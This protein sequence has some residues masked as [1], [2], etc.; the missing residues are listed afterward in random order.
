MSIFD[1]LAAEF[2]REA[3]SW[4]AQTVSKTTSKGLALAYIDARDVMRRLDEAVG[5]ENWTDRY[6]V[7]GS[8]T[9]CY[10]SIRLNGEWIVKADGA[11][12]T[13]VEA[14]KGSIS[15]AFKRAAVK[16]GIGRYL[17]DLKTPW[18]PC[19]FEERNGK[20]VWKKW[21]ADPWEY[22]GKP[23]LAQA[24]RVNPKK[25]EAQKV[26][27]VEQDESKARYIES[28]KDKIAQRA[29]TEAE[30]R[31]WW[32]NEGSRRRAF[33]LSQDEVDQLKK[34]LMVRLDEFKR[35]A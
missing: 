23:P 29:I 13:D 34:L 3:V 7:H 25:A 9:I 17:Y 14:E 19:E 2:P 18:V 27:P 22:V 21:T 11:G 28:C 10:L 1:E 35:A 15:D 4:R 16:W 30:L 26:S 33:D 5:P 8:K 6:E 24:P 31:N 12:D 32:S 20:A